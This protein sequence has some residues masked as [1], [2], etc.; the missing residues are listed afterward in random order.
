[1]SLKA[2]VA[3]LSG[4]V[5]LTV[6]SALAEAATPNDAC[7]VLNAAQVGAAVGAKVEEGTHVTSTFTKTCTWVVKSGDITVTLNIQPLSMY[8]A[9]KGALAQSETAQASGVGDE[10]YYAGAGTT[11]GLAVK[12]GGSAF[13]VSVYSNK[14][15]LE[16]RKEIEKTL[17]LQAVAKF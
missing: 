7:Q 13:K 17:A 8:Q 10:A 5:V 15:S 12:K 6:V 2:R 1:M 9:G 14:F 11:T 16:R 3:A 4:A